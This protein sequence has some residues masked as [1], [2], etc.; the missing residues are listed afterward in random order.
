MAPEGAGRRGARFGSVP[1]KLAPELF[2]SIN[3]PDTRRVFRSFALSPSLSLRFR[4]PAHSSS[5][6]PF[7]S[8]DAAPLEMKCRGFINLYFPPK[9]FEL[10]RRFPII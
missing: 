7:H 4:P 3:L 9:A 2:D 6:L 10:E 8:P 1:G 5:F